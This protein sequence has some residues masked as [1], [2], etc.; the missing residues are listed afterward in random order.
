MVA[1]ARAQVG[2]R[3]THCDARRDPAEP[4][5]AQDWQRHSEAMAQQGSKAPGCLGVVVFGGVLA[6]AVFG[7]LVPSIEDHLG[8]PWWSRFWVRAAAVV[9]VVVYLAVMLPTAGRRRARCEAHRPPGW[10][11]APNPFDREQCRG[12]AVAALFLGLLFVACFAPLYEDGMD[13]GAPSSGWAWVLAGAALLC[14]LVAWASWGESYGAAG[15][16]DRRYWRVLQARDPVTAAAAADEAGHGPRWEGGGEVGVAAKGISTVVGV[17][18]GSLAGHATELGLEALGFAATYPARQSWADGEA[19]ARAGRRVVAIA[20]VQVALAQ[21]GRRGRPVVRGKD[22]VLLEQ[23]LGKLLAAQERYEQARPVPPTLAA[24][25][26]EPGE[27]DDV[28]PSDWLPDCYPPEM[29]RL[30][31]GVQD[32]RAGDPRGLGARGAPGVARQ[33]ARAGWPA[34]G[35]PRHAKGS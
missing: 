11:R 26:A 35:L 9:F 4:A 28:P 12:S 7:W 18:G 3:E 6:A 27:P 1:Q 15:R 33:A 21:V 14:A 32:S 23:L 13:T 2:P 24:V 19:C 31:V 25:P 8:T 20:D 30:D 16:C 34:P 10:E 5:T 29:E 22:R 17:F